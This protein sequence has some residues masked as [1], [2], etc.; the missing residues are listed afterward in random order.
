LNPVVE[1]VCARIPLVVSPGGTDIH[2]D[3]M[4][5][6]RKEIIAQVCRKARFLISQSDEILF[7]LKE[8]FPE[9]RERVV[10]IPKSFS[11][12]GNENFDLRGAAEC[13]GGNLLF[14]F[15]AGIRPV[16]RNLECLRMLGGVHAERPHIRVVFAGAALD[17]AY[18]ADFAE[19]VERLRAF[20]RWIPPIAPQAIRSVYRAADIIL[21]AS[22]SEGLSN[23]LLEATAAGRP[24]L[25]SK[26]PGNRW[27]VLGEDGNHPMGLLYDLDDPEDFLKKALI[28]IDEQEVRRKLGEAGKKRAARL[29][30][31]EE[32]ARHLSRVYAMALREG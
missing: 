30:K 21:N 4:V 18:A 24:I 8:L 22:Y 14:F 28:L 13:D 5:E 10:F 31:P 7:R 32:E 25:A 11:W 23:A 29:P 26:I 6:G 9:L 15:P 27:P 2:A 12:M 1:V 16:K 3:W 19:E 17:H 20:A